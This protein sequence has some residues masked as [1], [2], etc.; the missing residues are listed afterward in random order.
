M[1]RL[2]H[3]SAPATWKGRLWLSYILPSN[4]LIAS[5]HMGKK[6][7]FQINSIPI[8]LTAT[9]HPHSYIFFLNLI[10]TS[11]VRKLKAPMIFFC[12]PPW[13]SL[14]LSF[15]LSGKFA[16]QTQLNLPLVSTLFPWAVLKESAP[17]FREKM[18]MRNVF[19]S[20]D[21]KNWFF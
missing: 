5:P 12:S 10:T 7:I 21:D 18:R 8:F 4:M 9:A 11:S 2:L 3:F 16:W 6:N 1:V 14:E 19:S 15:E 13:R 20:L 17:Q